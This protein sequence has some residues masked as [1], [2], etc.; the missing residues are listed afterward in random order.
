[1]HFS[2]YCFCRVS[3]YNSR[4]P[5]PSEKQD[6]FIS[7][8]QLSKCSS[9]KRFMK[10]ID[11]ANQSKSIMATTMET[12]MTQPDSPNV[13]SFAAPM[14]VLLFPA[15]QLPSNDMKSVEYRLLPCTRNIY[16]HSSVDWRYPRSKYLGFVLK[17]CE[18]R[19]MT[20]VALKWN[21]ANFISFVKG[22]LN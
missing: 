4:L 2:C 1:M 10:E 12:K 3:W 22:K 20:D 11:F 9:W 16:R 7:C 19:W 17:M 14:G 15:R 13:V 18:L 8:E 5:M 21:N 6:F